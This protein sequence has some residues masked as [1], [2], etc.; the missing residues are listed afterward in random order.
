MRITF[1]GELAM[2]TGGVFRE[3]ISAFW[4]V[5]YSRFC[6]GDALLVPLVHP[7][8]DINVF[9][10]LGKVLSH[11]YLQCGFLPLRIAF[12]ALAAM[13]LGT[14]VRI[15]NSFLISSFIDSLNCYEQS[16]LKASLES[17]STFSPDIQT[18]LVGIISRFVGRQLPTPLNLKEIVVQ[19]ARFQFHI[20]PFSTLMAVNS[21][22]PDFE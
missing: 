8:S 5:V 15:P 20:R 4:E 12:P 18:K 11:G 14:S 10:Q 13:L 17:K 19:L 6:D 3:M 16:L 21:G 7:G 9:S 2:D 22:I 1:K